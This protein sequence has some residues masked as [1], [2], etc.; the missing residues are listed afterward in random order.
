MPWQ[1]CGYGRS[2]RS[3]K[4]IRGLTSEAAAG[5]RSRR[6][7]SHDSTFVTPHN[8]PFSTYKVGSEDASGLIT[9]CFRRGDLAGRVPRAVA[10]FPAPVFL[11]PL[12]LGEGGRGANAQRQISVGA[13]RDPA[14]SHGSARRRFAQGLGSALTDHAALS[15]EVVTFAAM[16]RHSS[17]LARYWS[18]FVMG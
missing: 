8:A 16:R 11:R 9:A 4:L 2:D 10:S 17:A 5:F 13:F 1:L 18:D 14:P 7:P 12:I 15:I 6:G 3:T